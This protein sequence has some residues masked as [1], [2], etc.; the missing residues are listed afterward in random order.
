MTVAGVM[1]MIDPYG[2]P[3]NRYVVYVC[4][5]QILLYQ[6]LLSGN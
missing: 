5:K 3:S 1:E 4:E 2:Q 6:K